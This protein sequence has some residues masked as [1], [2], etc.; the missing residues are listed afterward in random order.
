MGVACFGAHGTKTLSCAALDGMRCA[1]S[2]PLLRGSGG[3]TSI[4]G[5]TDG[6]V[7]SCTTVAVLLG[8]RS[9]TPGGGGSMVGG[10]VEVLSS[11]VTVRC[12][13]AAPSCG[14][15][16]EDDDTPSMPDIV[17]LP[18][19]NGNSSFASPAGCVLKTRGLVETIR[20]GEPLRPVDDVIAAW[21]LAVVDRSRS[22]SLS[23]CKTFLMGRPSSSLNI[24]LVQ[25]G[26]FRDSVPPRVPRAPTQSQPPCERRVARSPLSRGLF[27]LARQTEAVKL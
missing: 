7:A 2:L 8:S 9:N 19:D 20:L 4:G 17:L 1:L 12:V 11:N 24:G 3:M 10:H 15:P 27:E 13:V 14:C 21:R 6:G 23:S 26:I 5:S 18:H 25:P 16:C 22:S